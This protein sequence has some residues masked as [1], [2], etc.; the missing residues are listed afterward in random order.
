MPRWTQLE[1]EAHQTRHGFRGVAQE[2][3]A[4]R[5]AKPSRESELHRL[6]GQ[7]INRRG[8]LCCHGSMHTAT[9]RTPGEPDFHCLAPKGRHFMVEC[10]TKTGKLSEDQEWFSA[11]ANELGHSVWI[12][13]SIEE[14]FQ[15]AQS[16][17]NETKE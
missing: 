16:F 15:V 3:E 4:P 5:K 2:V 1:A 12:V 13:R 14:W 6:I 7:D 17:E 10:K 9:K 11:R 8:W